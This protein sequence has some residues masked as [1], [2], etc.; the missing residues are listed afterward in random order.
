MNLENFKLFISIALLCNSVVLFGQ[1]Q[2]IARLTYKVGMK[3]H[4]G[5]KP[6]NKGKKEYNDF[7]KNIPKQTYF[8]DINN[9]QSIFLWI[10]K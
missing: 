4:D 7:F 9:N 2:Y 10:K 8:L 5:K 1:N 6:L 3:L